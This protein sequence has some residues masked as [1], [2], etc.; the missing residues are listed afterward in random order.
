LVALAGKRSETVGFQNRWDSW[1]QYVRFSLDGVL[2][3]I[4]EAEFHFDRYNPF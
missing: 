4:V 3:D 1:K 2:G